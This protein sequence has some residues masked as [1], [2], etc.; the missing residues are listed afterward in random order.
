MSMPI[1]SP[2]PFLRN[3]FGAYDAS[4]AMVSVPLSAM[5]LGSSPASAS[6]L[7]RFRFSGCGSASPAALLVEVCAEDD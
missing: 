7:A 4:V 5:A 2:W 6:S 1:G 3:S